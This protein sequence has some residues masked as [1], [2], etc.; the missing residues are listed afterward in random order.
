MEESSSTTGEIEQ[1]VLDAARGL[2]THYGYDKT[3]M[4]D[5]V[6]ESGV[7]KST[8]YLRWKKKEDLFMA[9]VWRE[10]RDYTADWFSRI[11]AD[12]SGGTYANFMRHALEAYFA[13]PFL[14]ALYTSDR[15]VMGRMTEQ[16]GV[17]HLFQRRMGLFLHF[18]QEMQRAGVVRQEIDGQALAYLMNSL[19]FG[20]L[21]ISGNLPDEITPPIDKVMN[22]MVQM[23]DTLVTPEGGGDS[24]KG[25][26]ILRDFKRRLDE[27]IQDLDQ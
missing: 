10:A 27:W 22:M 12:P 4:N 14:T 11:E 16:L 19:H 20:L 2:F 18:F 25:K 6:R 13:N 17:E 5:I 15:R 8:I 26:Q 24:E 3:T 7:A 23:V 21:Q 9:L 1:R